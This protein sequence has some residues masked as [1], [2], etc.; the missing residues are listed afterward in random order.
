MITDLQ[1]SAGP[2]SRFFASA[3]ALS[4][5]VA[6][7]AFAQDLP[8][9]KDPLEGITT[10]GQP[11][12]EQF[13]AVAAAGF[14]TVIDLRTPAEDR[15]LDEKAT[16]EKLGMGYMNLPV[17]G[18][19]G[20]TYANAAAL[21]KLLAE[22]PRP[23]L[24]HCSTGNRVGALLALRA[25]LDGADADSALSLGVAAGVTRLKDT[26]EQKLAAGHD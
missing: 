16:V 18:A 24:I 3:L 20:V 2:R 1:S 4:F 23:V 17:E 6:A 7:S 25:K 5:L 10:A 14:K 26:V 12:A 19:K 15:G 11:N 9:R 13:A 22:A 8:N 21:E